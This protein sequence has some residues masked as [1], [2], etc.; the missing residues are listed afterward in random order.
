MAGMLEAMSRFER[1]QSSQMSSPDDVQRDAPAPMGSNTDAEDSAAH[2]AEL[3]RRTTERRA[4]P[5]PS[6]YADPNVT[7]AQQPAKPTPS[8]A[9]PVARPVEQPAVEHSVAQPVTELPAAQP[10]VEHPVAQPVT[11]HPD[12]QPDVEH[13]VAQPVTE[14]PVAQPV[15]PPDA[16]QARPSMR[17]PSRRILLAAGAVVVL[18][19]GGWALSNTFDPVAETPPT[20]T[21][22][23]KVITPAGYALK[24]TDVI[25]DCASHSRGR[26]Q[27]SFKTENCVKATRLLATGQVHGRPVIFVASRIQMASAVAAASAKQVLDGSGTGNLNDLLREGKTFPGAPDKMP[28]S[29]YASVQLGPVVTVA[30]A[31]FV[32]GGR[33]SNTDPALRAAA[34]QV[35]ANLSAQS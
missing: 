10:D 19:S 32:D 29:G 6:S 22:K 14:H 9:Q 5:G 8:L 25:T 26:T 4:A 7:V 2:I 33:S 23:S 12:A 20:S 18:I 35:A 24:T 13:P 21:P 16:P 1:D 15:L 30:E 11:E 34:A 28:I 31:G 17:Q 3:V 27:A